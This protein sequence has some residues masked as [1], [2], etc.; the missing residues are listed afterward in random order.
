[1]LDLIVKYKKNH[2]FLFRRM[3]FL[4][5]IY[6][7]KKLN[8]KRFGIF[9]ITEF[10]FVYKNAF[11]TRKVDF[12]GKGFGDFDTQEILESIYELSVAKVSGN[13]NF[14][15]SPLVSLIFSTFYLLVTFRLSL[16]LV[17][18]KNLLVYA[19]SAKRLSKLY[20]IHKDLSPRGRFSPNSFY[21]DEKIWIFDFETSA[22]TKY[23]FLADVVDFLTTEDFKVFL[24]DDFIVFLEKHLF[25][26][27]ISHI[28]AFQ[29]LYLLLSR[30]IFNL[31]KDPVKQKSLYLLLEKIHLEYIKRR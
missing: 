31:R 2:F 29:Q 19:I 24:F 12:K 3:F 5:E 22:V 7:H 30:R 9:Q 16:A 14:L 23:F 15:L 8:G 21:N 1:M 18:V 6:F 20:F 28:A 26:Y 10:A 17:I 11:A 27:E 25:N 4:N 13:L